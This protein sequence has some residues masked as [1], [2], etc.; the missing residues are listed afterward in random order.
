MKNILI[1]HH[2]ERSFEPSLSL[3]CWLIDAIL[4]FSKNKYDTIIYNRSMINPD[5]LDDTLSGT[6]RQLCT[7]YYEEEISWGYEWED[8]Y[9]EDDPDAYN[10]NK[11]MIQISCNSASAFP[12]PSW[13]GEV[14]LDDVNVSICGCFDRECVEELRMFL[15]AVDVKFEEVSELI[16]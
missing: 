5:E 2:I 1:V 6:L 3:S 4:H 13:L 12:I 11:D 15:E 16:V 8:D 9:D 10:P 7:T 14:T